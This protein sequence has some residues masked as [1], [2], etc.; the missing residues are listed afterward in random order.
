MRFTCS[1]VA[2]QQDV[3]A[4]S[5]ELASRQLQHQG[6]VQRWDSQEIEAVHDLDDWEL[7]LSDATFGSPALAVQQ[8]QFG[9]AQQVALIPS[10]YRSG[11]DFPPKGGR[12]NRRQRLEGSFEDLLERAKIQNF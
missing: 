5:E 10:G 2:R 12:T 6:L 1:A 3:L 9:D 4:A 7:R 11:S 8:L